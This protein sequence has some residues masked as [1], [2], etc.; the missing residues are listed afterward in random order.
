MTLP[1]NPTW[2]SFAMAQFFVLDTARGRYLCTYD[3]NRGW[4]YLWGFAQPIKMLPRLMTYKE[5]R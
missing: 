1:I 5:T 3:H 4:H 2:Q